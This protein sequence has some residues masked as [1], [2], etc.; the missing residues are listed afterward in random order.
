MGRK[1][2]GKGTVRAKRE[3]LPADMSDRMFGASARSI[4]SARNPSTLMIR[5]RSARGTW[6]GGGEA[7]RGDGDTTAAHNSNATRWNSRIAM[8]RPPERGARV[9]AA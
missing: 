1:R 5:T 9:T 4:T 2:V 8:R 6:T 7:A 3:K